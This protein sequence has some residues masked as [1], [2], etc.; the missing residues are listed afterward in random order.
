MVV[1]VPGGRRLL[2]P[3]MTKRQHLNRI[4]AGLASAHPGLKDLCL[5]MDEFLY[6]VDFDRCM[7]VMPI[8]GMLFVIK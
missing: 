1:M 2:H 6:L 5:V 7:M 8:S 4:C 3:E